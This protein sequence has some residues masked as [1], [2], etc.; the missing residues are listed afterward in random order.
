MTQILVAY[1]TIDGHTGAIS[2]RIADVLRSRG[3]DV[4]TAN[5]EDTDTVPEGCGAVILAGPIHVN[6]HDAKVVDFAARNLTA[7]SS[8]PSAF[9]SVSLGVLGDVPEAQKHVREFSVASGWHPG[10][11][12]LAAGALLYTRYN[13]V[14]RQLMRTIAASKPGILSTDTGRDHDYTDWDEVERFAEAFA[15]RLAAA[16][17]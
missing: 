3:H 16:A 5:V 2:E 7:L 10:T 9:L 14:K 15:D 12:W 17:A 4:T 13:F 11:V 8:L 1:G 6:K